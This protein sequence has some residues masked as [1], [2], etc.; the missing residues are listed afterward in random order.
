MKKAKSTPGRD[1]KIRLSKEF[2]L[3]STL[4][5]EAAHAIVCLI[6]NIKPE[7]VFIKI[8]QVDKGLKQAGGRH[9]L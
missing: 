4:F 5:H 1:F 2:D 9:L 3:I 8:E 6:Y 7:A